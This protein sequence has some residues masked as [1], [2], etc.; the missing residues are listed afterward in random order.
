MYTSWVTSI[1]NLIM[2][3]LNL[4]IFSSSYN[5]AADIRADRWE[6]VYDE[7]GFDED[8]YDSEG[9]NAEGCNEAGYD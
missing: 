5:I 8:G 6:H 9:Y 4:W 1:L 2:T 3:I 7:D